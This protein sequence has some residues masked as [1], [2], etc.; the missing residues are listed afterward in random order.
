MLKC[1]TCRK[2]KPT[3]QFHK[4]SRTNRGAAYACISCTHK[5]NAIRR[6]LP[7]YSS[8]DNVK[9]RCDIPTAQGY[10]HYGGRGVTYDKELFK[11]YEMFWSVCSYL[12]DEGCVKYPNEELTIDRKDND[13]NYTESNIRFVPL[14]VNC[15][16][17]SNNR[18]IKWNGKSQSLALWAREFNL[19]QGV[20]RFRLECDWPMDVI[21]YTPNDPNLV[22][23]I[24]KMRKNK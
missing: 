7:A 19:P 15:N 23:A 17:K 11:T 10:K 20:V 13:G 24:N 14:W 5:R 9:K 16:N 2:L 1:S 4:C 8:Y 18:I 3:D 6:Q 22:K 12:Y 21:K